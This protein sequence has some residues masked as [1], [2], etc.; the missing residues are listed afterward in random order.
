MACQEVVVDYFAE[1]GEPV[2][3]HANVAGFD[4]ACVLEF[5][6]CLDELVYFFVLGVDLFLEFAL[7]LDEVP[8]GGGEVVASCGRPCDDAAYCDAGESYDG[9][10]KF[11]HKTK[12]IVDGL[13]MMVA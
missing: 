6:S 5:V 10:D 11:S 8:V 4:V 3:Y 12:S 7:Y 2:A 9:R 13:G 1:L